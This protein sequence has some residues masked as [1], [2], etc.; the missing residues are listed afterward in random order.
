MT[1]LRLYTCIERVAAQNR[2]NPL[3]RHL[4]RPNPGSWHS[5]LSWTPNVRYP[6]PNPWPL[7][8]TLTEPVLDPCLQFSTLAFC[9][10]RARFEAC[11]GKANKVALLSLELLSSQFIYCICH[12]ILVHIWQ[13]FVANGDCNAFSSVF[14]TFLSG[15]ERFALLVSFSPCAAL[16]QH[17]NFFVQHQVLFFICSFVF[18]YAFFVSLPFFH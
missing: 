16:H 5:R 3:D 6:K 7:P 15:L 10:F 2:R 12:S 1:N 8:P 13:P 4:C 18:L 14:A 17:F 9:Y 11:R